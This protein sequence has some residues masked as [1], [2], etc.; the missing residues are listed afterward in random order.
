MEMSQRLPSYIIK[1]LVMFDTALMLGAQPDLTVQH[2]LF[3]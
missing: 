3:I 2:L 1:A